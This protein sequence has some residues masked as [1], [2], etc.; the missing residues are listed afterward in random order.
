MTKERRKY[1]RFKEHFFILC[2]FV[3]NRKTLDVRKNPIGVEENI[4]K[5]ISGGGI[6]FERENFVSLLNEILIEIYFP[7]QIHKKR[8]IVA[9]IFTLGEA[10][11]VKKIG[12]GRC[13]QGSNKYQ[14]GVGFKDIKTKD[15]HNIIEYVIKKLS[16]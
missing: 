13:P 12:K 8:K 5:N 3:Q 1:P 7:L 11:W 9:S 16:S 15:R 10:V 6:M 4:A 2:R 14:I